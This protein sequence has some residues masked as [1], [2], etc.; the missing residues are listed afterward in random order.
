VEE[1]FEQGL[2]SEIRDLL[3]RGYKWSDPGLQGIGYKEFF[4]MQQGCFTFRDLKE[5]IIKH[6]KAYAKRQ[7]TFFRSLSEVHWFHPD[8]FERIVGRIL[9]F[10][11]NPPLD[12]NSF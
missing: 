4:I 1:M 10:L 3:K 8:D 7:M 9:E 2:V 11:L 6:T 12:Y 5:L